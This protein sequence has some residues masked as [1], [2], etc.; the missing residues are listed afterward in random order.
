MKRFALLAVCLC[1]ASG[2][3]TVLSISGN[4]LLVGSRPLNLIVN[5]SFEADG[6]LAPNNAYWATG[7][8]LSP[9]MSLTG[10]SASGQVASYGIWGSDG[11]GGVKGSATLPH[12]TNGL[13]FGAG[14]MAGVNPFPLE[15]PDGQVLFASGPAI[16]PKPTDGPVMLQQTV[17]GLNTSA[18]Y[19]LDFW[20]SGEEL[21]GGQFLVDGFFGLQITGEP[22]IYLAAPSGSGL[23]GPSQRYQVLF[24]P[25]SPNVTFRW[26]NWGHYFDANNNL[27]N[28][29]VLDDVILN[30]MEIPEPTG[31]ALIGFGALLLSR[32]TKA[33]QG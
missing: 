1:A 17:S 15:A 23:V 3:A 12:G 4:D 21:A 19:L 11:L 6:G 16:F 30:Q 18:A 31:I 2:R 5:G 24:N 28:E 13:Y 9:T 29:L 20:T 32:R 27:S 25:T 7:T 22:T 10:W 33:Q 26:I 14:I 8:T